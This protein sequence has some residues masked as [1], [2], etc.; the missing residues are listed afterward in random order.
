M[1]QIGDRIPYIIINGQKGVRNYQLAEDPVIF[2]LKD[3]IV[4]IILLK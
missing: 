4:F 3:K 1:F 2:F